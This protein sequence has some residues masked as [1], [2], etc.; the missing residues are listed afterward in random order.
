MKNLMAEI[1][2]F[3]KTL[4]KMRALHKLKNGDYA[5]DSNPHE[6]FE[7]QALIMSWFKNDIDKAYAGLI[8]LKLAR[9]A[10][11]LNKTDLPN[12][13]SIDDSFID[14][15]NYAILWKCKRVNH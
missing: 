1:P 13:E 15:A 4:D 7:R 8:A 2:E 10:T 11:L 6:N 3:V 12:N 5:A 9:L 14:L